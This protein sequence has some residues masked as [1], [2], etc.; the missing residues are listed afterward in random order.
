MRQPDFG[1]A[2]ESSELLPAYLEALCSVSPYGP[3]ASEHFFIL[4][5]TMIAA[6]MGILARVRIHV[7]E[8]IPPSANRAFAY[9]ENNVAHQQRFLKA[10]ASS[11]LL[12][13]CTMPVSP[14]T[15]DEDARRRHTHRDFWREMYTLQEMTIDTDTGQLL[16][17]ALV[18]AA[19][20]VTPPLSYCLSSIIC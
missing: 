2:G 7:R 4:L 12:A 9:F 13:V 18:M 14:E 5:D 11:S 20:Q 8:V 6:L 17:D 10:M 16:Y 3:P 15:Y 1:S 19:L